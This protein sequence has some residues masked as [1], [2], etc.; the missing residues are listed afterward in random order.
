MEIHIQNFLFRLHWEMKC[1]KEN[2]DNK[3]VFASSIMQQLI[4]VSSVI[5]RIPGDSPASS[6][7]LRL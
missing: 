1:S 6:L 5:M 3:G 4:T 2:K 7:K